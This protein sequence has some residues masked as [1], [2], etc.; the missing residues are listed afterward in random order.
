M[1]NLKVIG[2]GATTKIY[3]DGAKA[4]KLYVN[5]P[6]GEAEREARLQSFA[7]NAGLPVPAVFGVRDLSEGR[8]A[9]DM[10]Y[11]PGD[12]LMRDDMNKDERHNAIHALVKLQ[13]MVHAVNAAGLPK[14]SDRLAWKL[15]TALIL[16][17]RQRAIC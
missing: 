15:S 14:Q 4:V 12:P 16:T 7:Y 8:T 13:R 10:E 9:L 17:S 1:L 2:E 6:P 3:L 11:I 5:A